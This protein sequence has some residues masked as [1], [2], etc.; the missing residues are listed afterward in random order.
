MWSFTCTRPCPD[1]GP[2]EFTAVALTTDG[3]ETTT[4]LRPSLAWGRSAGEQP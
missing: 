3:Y 4:Y 1:R 2:S